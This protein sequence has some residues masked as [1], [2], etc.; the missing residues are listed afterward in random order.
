[1]TA[2]E[3]RHP[4]ARPHSRAAPARSPSTAAAAPPRWPGCCSRSPSASAW[5]RSHRCCRCPLV[6]CGRRRS[7]AGRRRPGHRG[8]RR[9]RLE[10]R[11]R[12]ALAAEAEGGVR[13]EAEAAPA[14]RGRSRLPIRSRSGLAIR[15]RSAPIRGRPGARGWSP[16]SSFASADRCFATARRTTRWSSAASAIA[17]ARRSGPRAGSGSRSTGSP[18]WIANARGRSG[19]PIGSTGCCSQPTSAGGV[20]PVRPPRIGPGDGHRAP[21]RAGRGNRGRRF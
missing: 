8:G 3:P 10:V 17:S 2:A 13:S 18:S 12:S 11:G 6:R 4:R 9:A 15:R 1:M 16:R 14:G 5:W 21:V 7:R 19:S 20:G